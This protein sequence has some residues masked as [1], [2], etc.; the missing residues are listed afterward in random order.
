[1]QVCNVNVKISEHRHCLFY[2][3]RDIVKLQV[4]ENL[5][6]ARLY[7]TDNARSLGIKK[8]HTDFDKRLSSREFVKKSKGIL[9]AFK[10]A[11]YNYVFSH[12]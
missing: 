9:C 4:E 8:L 1:M 3:V 5:V 2:G 6:S 10:I 7:L 11:C 12:S